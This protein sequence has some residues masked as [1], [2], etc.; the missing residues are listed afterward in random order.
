MPFHEKYQAIYDYIIKPV[1]EARSLN[2]YRADDYNNVNSVILDIWKSIRK[3]RLLIAD[4]TEQRPNV[5]YELGLA[6]D[7]GK[8]VIIISQP[9]EGNSFPFDLLHLRRIEYQDSVKGAESLKKKLSATLDELLRSTE[10]KPIVQQ[11]FPQKQGT[12]LE[13]EIVKDFYVCKSIVSNEVK[14]RIDCIKLRK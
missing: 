5:M 9:G 6:H 13:D 2:C 7:M 10:V 4:L 11:T 3:S 1:V 8:Q 14:V 12:P